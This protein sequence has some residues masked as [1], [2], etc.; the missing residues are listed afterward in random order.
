NLERSWK[1][2]FDPIFKDSF[3]QVKQVPVWINYSIGTQRFEKAVDQDDV[4]LYDSIEKAE[5]PYWYPSSRMMEGKESRRNDPL[6]MTHVHHFYYKD[7]LYWLAALKQR[8]GR[9]N[10]RFLVTYSLINT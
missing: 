1:T 9:L 8:S 2:V 4:A 3:R 6:G 10:Y 5:I 7:S